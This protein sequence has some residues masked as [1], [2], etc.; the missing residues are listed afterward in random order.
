MKL[1][2]EAMNIFHIRV[3]RRWKSVENIYLMNLEIPHTLPECLPLLSNDS[4]EFP[5]PELNPVAEKILVNTDVFYKIVRYKY[6]YLCGFWV[7]F[8]VVAVDPCNRV[9]LPTLCHGFCCCK[10]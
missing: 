7:S 3:D 5:D 8:A 9:R 6:K 10:D 2:N 1:C 4:F